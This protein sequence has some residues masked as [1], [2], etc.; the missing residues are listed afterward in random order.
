MLKREAR[1]ARK[2]ADYKRW[3]ADDKGSSGHQRFRC[4]PHSHP[5]PLHYSHPQWPA[6]LVGALNGIC[7]PFRRVGQGREGKGN[8]LCCVRRLSLQPTPGVD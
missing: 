1:K 2:E 4:N 6:Q 3:P 5:H 7:S 8:L